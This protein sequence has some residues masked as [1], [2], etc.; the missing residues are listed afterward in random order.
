MADRSETAR[1]VHGV[2]AGLW[3]GRFDDGEL[4]DHLSLGEEGLGLDSIEMVEL[5]V[6]CADRLGVPAYDAD[7]LLDSGPVT[8]RRLVEH[9]A[10]A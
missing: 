2:L 10:D 3:P 8:I 9:L 4:Q 7:D 5:I 6:E 1:I